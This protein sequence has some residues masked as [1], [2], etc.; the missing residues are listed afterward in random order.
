MTW[1]TVTDPGHL[2][3]L[4]QFILNLL[5]FQIENIN[6]HITIVD[7]MIQLQFLSNKNK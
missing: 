3:G 5:Y 6:N 7:L 1:N 2:I 4:V